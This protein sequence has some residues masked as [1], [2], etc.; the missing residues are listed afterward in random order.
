[1]KALDATA[2]PYLALSAIISAGM[3]GIEHQS[4]LTIKDCYKAPA[5][6]S[7]DERIE[8]GLKTRMPKSPE[9]AQKSLLEDKEMVQALG[10]DLIKAFSSVNAVCFET[11]EGG[12]FDIYII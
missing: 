4:A 1:L 10:A 6:M 2:N 12:E 7:A 5:Q 9:S 3:L 8:R 11:F